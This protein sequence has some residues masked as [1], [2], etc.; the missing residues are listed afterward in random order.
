[1]G[2][3]IPVQLRAAIVRAFDE[4]G[5]KY[6]QIVS[7]LGVCE[8]TVA[9]VLRRHR[10]SGSIEPRPRGGG[11]VSPIHGKMATLLRAIVSRMPDA[12]VNELTEALMRD[13]GTDTSRSA[14]QRAL[15]RL[16]YSRKKSRSWRRSATPKSTGSGGAS[17]AR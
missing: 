4:E 14:V 3:P 7:V 8:S 1:M 11:N 6:R 17:S 10:E 2:A 13:S 5:L 15:S 16:G 12:T 9:R